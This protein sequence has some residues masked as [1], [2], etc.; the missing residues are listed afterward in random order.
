M[1]VIIKNLEPTLINRLVK[2]HTILPQDK[3]R[4]TIK[5]LTNNRQVSI[6][7]WEDKWEEAPHTM[8]QFT[9]QLT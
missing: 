2:V 4:I 5:L 3:H 9:H 1:G 6:V 7:L 8:Q